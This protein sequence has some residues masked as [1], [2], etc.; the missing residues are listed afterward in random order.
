MD[1]SFDPDAY[2]R[3]IGERL[4]GKFKD[5][6]AGTTAPTVGS[7][8]EQ[9]V[10][11]QLGQVLPRGVGVGEGFVIDSYGGTSR[12]QDVVLY[13]RDLCPVFSINNT[14]QTTFYPC[15]GV[16]AVGEIKS[17]LDRGSLEDAFEKVTSV[18]AL[19]RHSVAHFMPHPET[20]AP[21]PRRRKYLSPGGDES[22]INLDQ[23]RGQEESNRIFG[24]V[25]A[26]ESRSNRE[27]L[28]AAFA[29]LSAGKDEELLPN[30]LVTLDGHVVGW[31]KIA[32]GERK[33]V[34]RTA[35]G[36]YGVRVY[37]DGP[38]GWQPAW[39]AAKA[40]HVGGLEERETF[41]LL[42]RWLRHA[43]DQGRTSHVQAFDRYFGT[44][45]GGQQAPMFC[46][47]KLNLSDL[48][49]HVGDRPDGA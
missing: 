6:K 3:R 47:P 46:V 15:E 25:L 5:A 20:G 8:A 28:V 21:V 12:Q 48:A 30:L 44:K 27:S 43:A 10:R 41:R 24:F 9:P 14:P 1:K 37:K 7:A 40:T 2:L 23:A 22:V 31:G 29:A 33:E 34:R 49:R 38:E 11:E 18:K 42:V 36:T 35:G 32:K 26:G 45:S 13:E 39:S 19:R 4:V 17:R 16:I